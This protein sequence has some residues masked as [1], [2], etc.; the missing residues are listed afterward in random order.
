MDSIDKYKEFSYQ[1]YVNGWGDKRPEIV[2][3]CFKQNHKLEQKT[4]G[5][6]VTEVSCE[7]CK[8][9]FLIDSTD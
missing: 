4:V 8:Y 1:G 9:Y 2:E 6:C 5:R 7:I 3:K